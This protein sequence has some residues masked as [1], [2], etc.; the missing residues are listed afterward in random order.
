MK[1]P[2]PAALNRSSKKS[3]AGLPTF[4]ASMPEPSAHARRAALGSGPSLSAPRILRSTGA[5]RKVDEPALDVGLEELDRD[6]L[7]DV[8]TLE[9]VDHLP[10]H[11]GSEDPDPGPLL[12]RGGDHSLEPLPDSRLQEER[13]GRLPHLPLHL[14][15]V[16][17][18]LRAVAR[19][20]LELATAVRRRATGQRGLEQA[21]RHEVR[22]AP[23]R[24]GGMG[25]V[26]DREAEVARR[27]SA[28]K[29]QHVLPP[30]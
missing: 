15:R 14:V 2:A 11:G 24:G 18:L 10:L 23:V 12:G 25:V 20:L 1:Y 19:Q 21:L 22:E 9:P 28:R 7:P 13:R 26:V 27:R 8:E 6:L 30:S 3:D 17:F 16:V 4:Q 5:A 29:L